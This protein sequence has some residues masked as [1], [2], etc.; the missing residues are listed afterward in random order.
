MLIRAITEGIDLKF[1]IDCAGT[2]LRRD[3]RC[4]CVLE[5]NFGESD[6][7]ILTSSV[8]LGRGL[9]NSETTTAYYEPRIPRTHISLS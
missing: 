2:G 3:R 1:E 7:G 6:E 8:E 9:L 5:R 4:R